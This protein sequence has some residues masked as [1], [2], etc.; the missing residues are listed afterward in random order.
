MDG[1]RAP[2]QTAAMS[3]AVA[4]LIAALAL[5]MGLW[6]YVTGTR[7]ASPPAAPV[8]GTAA[9]PGGD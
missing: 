3:R 2:V 6:L 1:A 8:E 7:D 4:L 9:P 5:G